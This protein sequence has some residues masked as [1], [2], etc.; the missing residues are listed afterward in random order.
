MKKNEI[1]IKEEFIK[2]DSAL[3]FANL[4]SS[5][6]Q[7]K[8]FIKEGKVKVNGEVCFLRGKKLYKDDTFIFENTE[9]II[10]NDN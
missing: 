5:G 6:G 3:K 1:K 4:V 9:Y 8:I 7:A 2:L 10:K